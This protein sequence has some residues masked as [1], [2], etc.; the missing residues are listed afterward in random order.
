MAIEVGD[1][2]GSSARKRRHENGA[3][4]LVAPV[5]VRRIDAGGP[6]G[7]MDLGPARSG[8]AYRALAAL[9][10]RDGWPAGFVTVP[11]DDGRVAAADL[12]AALDAVP[13]RA[14]ALGGRPGPR[15]EAGTV[16]VST[17]NNPGPLVRALESIL[18]GLAYGDRVLVV[19][20]RPASSTVAASL[21][22]RFGDDER[23]GYVEEARPGLGRA[24]NAAL[25]ACDTELIAFTDD[26]VIADEAWSRR[27]F[28]ALW[29]DPAAAVVTGLIVPLALETESQIVLEEFA[30]FAKGFARRRFHIDAPPA[31]DPLFPFAAGAFGSGANIGCRVPLLRDIAGYDDALGTGTPSRGGEDLDLFTRTLLAGH[32]LVYEPG[33]YVWHEHP[34]TPQRLQRQA[35]NYGAALSAVIAKQ[36]VV[37]D[38]RTDLLRRVPAG[39]RYLFDPTSRKNERKGAAYPRRLTALELAGMV[40]G[41]VGYLRSARATR[42]AARA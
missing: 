37:G 14:P 39:V 13:P 26:D 10:V 23:I 27:L 33:A 1:M 16:V 6:V 11:A 38:H 21:R 20:N 3:D 34:D 15:A 2:A 36:L 22:A 29:Q 35:F 8:G 12:R 7:D 31:G 4:G 28:D 41:P 24:R 25:A 17:C 9:V 40:V 42:R 32:A 30:G 18:A 19:E 5:A